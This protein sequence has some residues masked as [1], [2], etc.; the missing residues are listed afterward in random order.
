MGRSWPKQLFVFRRGGPRERGAPQQSLSGLGDESTATS[1]PRTGSGRHTPRSACSRGAAAACTRRAAAARGSMR[2][3]ARRRRGLPVRAHAKLP[4]AALLCALRGLWRPRLLPEVRCAAAFFCAAAAASRV[5][6]RRHYPRASRLSRD[7]PPHSSLL[8]S[9]RELWHLGAGC[10]P[11]FAAGPLQCAR[12]RSRRI[13][14]GAS[15]C[16]V[17]RSQAALAAATRARA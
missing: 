9:A 3:S 6:R 10:A 16:R 7:A 15:A 17:D 11:V 12:R 8:Y 2:I 4:D 13:L 1:S 14:R 5:S